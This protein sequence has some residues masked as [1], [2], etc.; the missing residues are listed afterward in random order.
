LVE[1]K[2]TL[3]PNWITGFTDAEGCFGVSIY[4]KLFCK[5]QWRVKP[6]FQIE[7][8]IKDLDLLLL[9]HIKDFFN[10]KGNIYIKNNKSAIYSVRDLDS[11][12]N[13]IIPHFDKY[14]LIT[15]KHSDFLLFKDIVKRISNKEH[16]D[17]EGLNRII[18]LKA[19]L[20]N[21]LS[22][23]LSLNF[24]NVNKVNRIKVNLQSIYCNLVAGFISGDG[25]FYVNILKSKDCKLGYSVK[26]RVSITQHSKDELLLNSIANALKCGYVYIHSKNGVVFMVSTF[27]AI[28]NI[29]IPLLN[30]NKIRGIK[31]LDFKDFCLVA[32][33][34][35]KKKH[36]TPEGLEEIRKIKFG[37]NKSRL[38]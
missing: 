27:E 8:H 9:L 6:S 13:F 12:I 28:Y 2:Y 15:Q 21:G 17:K 32:E 16:L 33:L 38:G 25:C 14:S 18:S 36:L 10:N 31:Y 23:K 37:M 20:N 24:P 26:L 22:K 19:S 35:N 3:D 1:N 29:I 11:I 34:I 4:N 5:T 7:L 30:K